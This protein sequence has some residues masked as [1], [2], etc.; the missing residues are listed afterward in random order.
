MLGLIDTQAGADG[1]LGRR[2]KKHRDKTGLK[3]YICW[4]LCGCC[5]GQWGVTAW[6][7]SPMMPQSLELLVSCRVPQ[8]L[9]LLGGGV[10]SRGNN[11]EACAVLEQTSITV[12]IAEGPGSTTK[13]SY[14]S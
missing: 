6:G 4:S 3:Q 2:K 8:H 11:L 1:A 13:P 7:L 5:D 9:D 14:E 10:S 12:F